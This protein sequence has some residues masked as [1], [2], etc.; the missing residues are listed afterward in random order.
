MST[1]EGVRASFSVVVVRERADRPRA[2]A[3]SGETP[4][5]STMLEVVTKLAKSSG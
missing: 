3:E 2:A 4:V 5:L 1:R